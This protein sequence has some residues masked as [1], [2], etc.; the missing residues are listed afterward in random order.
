[1]TILVAG[2]I[3]LETTLKIEGFP[4]HYN[5]VNYPFFGVNSTVSGVGY[6]VAK[7]FTMLGNSINFLSLIGNDSIGQLIKLTLHYDNIPDNYVLPLLEKTPQSVILYD[8]NGTR[9][10]NVDLKNIQESRYPIEKYEAAVAECSLAVL[11]NINFSR[12]FLAQTKQKIIATDVHALWNL[13]DEYNQEYMA[14]ADILFMSH[15]KLPVPPHEWIKQVQNRY[16]NE[17]IVV[18]LGADGVQMAV[19]KDNFNERIPAVK[20][21]EVVNTIG[22]GDAL[23]SAFVHFYH[24]TNDPYTA[25][26][27]AIVF[28]S[29]KIG[30]TG[31]AEGFLNEDVLETFYSHFSW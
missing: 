6:N 22:A 2:L 28:A 14:H 5:P 12:P 24:K 19:K 10:I 17:I 4:I 16:G 21:R 1:M 23:F 9:Q 27:K 13:E 31:A 30:T 29:Y 20:V 18:G 7:A 8:P 15:E 25:I 26:R 3:N 11:C